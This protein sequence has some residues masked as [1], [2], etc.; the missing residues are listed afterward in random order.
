MSNDR[1]T[2][3]VGDV[4]RSFNVPG[5]LRWLL[6]LFKG[7]RIPAGPVDILLTKGGAT[8]PGTGLDQPHR[9]GPPRVG[10]R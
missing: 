5:W 1:P 4:I 6:N 9:P 8:P 10:L 2:I 7:T 3:P